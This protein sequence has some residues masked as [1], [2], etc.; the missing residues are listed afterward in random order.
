DV[1]QVRTV[2]GG[3]VND[4]ILAVLSGGLRSWLLARGQGVSQGDVLRAMLPV[5]IAIPTHE[6]D[7]LGSKVAATIVDLPV[8]EPDPAV[9]V[10]QVSYQMA[11]LE[12]NDHFVGASNIA[13]IA[14]FGP[15]TLHALGARLGASLTR[16]VYN[17]VITNVPG[18]QHP[19]YAAGARMT[20][21]YPVVP[22]GIGQALSIG[23]TS[24]DGGVY[25]GL[26]AD[27]D[28]L[29][30]LDVLVSCLHDARMELLE[31]CEE[32]RRLR[33]VPQERA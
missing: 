16:R 4:A 10:Q 9:R 33:A 15:P 26:F 20:A 17:L 11:Q 5:S 28:A 13:D 8:G 31:R 25:L 12:E 24:Y 2:L 21:A 7:S 3:T 22:L 30:D 23:L 29:P 27:R 1:K 19:L 6:G 18:P 32:R 14:G